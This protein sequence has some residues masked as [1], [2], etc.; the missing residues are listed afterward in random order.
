MRT[1][2]EKKRLTWVLVAI[3]F[4]FANLIV[5]GVVLFNSFFPSKPAPGP[6]AG[7]ASQTRPA[8]S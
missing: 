7:P 4:F 3:F 6:G 5:V 8:G 1:P 2:A